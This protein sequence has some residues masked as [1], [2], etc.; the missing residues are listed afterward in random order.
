V[1]QTRQVHGIWGGLTE[2][3]RGRQIQDRKMA[4]RDTMDPPATA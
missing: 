4:G 3:E 1:L 2:D